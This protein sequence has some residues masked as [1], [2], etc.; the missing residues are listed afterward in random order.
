MDYGKYYWF[1]MSS[2]EEVAWS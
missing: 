1:E 2:S